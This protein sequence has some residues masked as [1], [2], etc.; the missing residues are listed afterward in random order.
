MSD[1]AR[2]QLRAA[3]AAEG[4]RM[5]LEARSDFS[6]LILVAANLVALGVAYASSMSLR[7]LMLVY[8]IQS[9]IIGVA[10]VVRIAGLQRFDTD[11]F[12]IGG[13]PVEEKPAVKRQTAAFFA[14]HYGFFHAGY[15]VFIAA[16]PSRAGQLAPLYVYAVLALIFAANHG[17]SLA[18]NMRRDAAGRPNIGT[19]MLLPYARIVPMHLTIVLGGAFIGGPVAFFFF[20]LLKTAADAVMH[21]VEH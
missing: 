2:A 17:Y 12:K 15:L 5:A 18:H 4:R 20:G 10:N 13:Q 7:D 14:V 11:G 8:W 6:L 21:V 19:L 9:V 16:A 3:L 1:P